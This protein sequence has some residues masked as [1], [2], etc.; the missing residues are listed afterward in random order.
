MKPPR[1]NHDNIIVE[2]FYCLIWWNCCQVWDGQ[3]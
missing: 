2:V 3:L 1:K